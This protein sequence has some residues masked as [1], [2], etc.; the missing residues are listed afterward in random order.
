MNKY[1]FVKLHSKG[2]RLS[3]PEDIDLIVQDRTVS[4]PKPLTE[5]VTFHFDY[6]Q[7]TLAVQYHTKAVAG[8]YKLSKNNSLS[9]TRRYLTSPKLVESIKKLIGTGWFRLVK[10][11]EY[12]IVKPD[13]GSV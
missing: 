8:A 9:T 4:F 6:E 10:T 12:Y 5:Y 11:G 7:K 1:N 3:Y 13:E 2:S